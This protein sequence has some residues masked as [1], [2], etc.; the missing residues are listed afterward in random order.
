MT[1]G[2][3]LRSQNNHAVFFDLDGVII[4]SAP[5]ITDIIQKMLASRG[6]TA[7]SEMLKKFVGPPLEQSFAALLDSIGEPSNDQNAA[8]WSEEFRNFYRIRHPETKAYQKIDKMLFEISEKLPC[9]IATSKSQ[10]FANAILKN[11]ELDHFFTVIVG[12]EPNWK[13]KSKL[14]V[15]RN[16]LS[17]LNIALHT[18]FTGEDCIMVGDRF[19]DIKA[20]NALGMI[21]IGV[22]WGIGDYAELVS[23]EPNFIVNKPTRVTK[24]SQK[25]TKNNTQFS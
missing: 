20:A 22:T 13:D 24:L 2:L 17:S 1:K 9:A 18:D 5:L 19:H 8:E 4:D 15:L 14:T 25:I 12:T 10:E 21:S 7:N 16:A 23:S 3:E 11:L 6:F